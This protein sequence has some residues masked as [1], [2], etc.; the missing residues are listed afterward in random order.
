MMNKN[1]NKTLMVVM[2]IL[3][4]LV[5]GLFAYFSTFEGDGGVV[6]TSSFPTSTP[7]VIPAESSGW[8]NTMPTPISVETK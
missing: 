6:R 3:M 1:K 5:I 7:T 8:W 2:I 4:L